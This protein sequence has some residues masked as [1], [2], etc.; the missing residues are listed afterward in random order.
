MENDKEKL[1]KEIDIFFKQASYAHCNFLILEQLNES[2]EK[3]YDEMAISNAFY[4]FTYNALLTTVV[5]ELSKIYDT[6]SR[7]TNI[8]KLFFKCKQNIEYFPSIQ[9]KRVFEDNEFEFPF[10]H[11]VSEKDEEFFK[12]DIVYNQQL[13]QLIF[14]DEPLKIEMTK[15][16]YFDLFEWRLNKANARVPNLIKQRNKIYAH[17]DL[18]TVFNMEKSMKKF[19]IYF[20]DIKILIEF[21]L[22][23]TSFAYTKLTRCQKAIEPINLKDLEYTL[24]FVKY[25]VKYREEEIER[26]IAEF[27]Q[28]NN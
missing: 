25:G 28:N 22:D 3:Y 19:P 21:A 4:S 6:H 1:I 7:S 11:T 15:D 23:F 18:E 14:D 24:D 13:N 8:E 2:R 16:R 10:V 27:D 20:E 9:L 12:N 5:M 26:Q 17:N